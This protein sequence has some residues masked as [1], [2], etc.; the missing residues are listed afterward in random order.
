MARNDYILNIIKQYNKDIDEYNAELEAEIAEKD[1]ILRDRDEFGIQPDP[2]YLE[3]IRKRLIKAG[4]LD[5]TGTRL[6]D[7]YLREDY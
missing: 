3:K 1:K 5:P 6:A 4:I 7:P 2:E